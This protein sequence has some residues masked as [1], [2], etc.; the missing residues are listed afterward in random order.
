[1][2]AVF[3]LINSALFTFEQS[4]SLFLINKSI[5]RYFFA[6]YMFKQG[7]HWSP[8][9]Q[10]CTLVGTLIQ[11]VGSHDAYGLKIQQ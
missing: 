11:T 5:L 7:Y 1:M 8:T 9:P 3:L 2:G 6:Y 10:Y 4:F